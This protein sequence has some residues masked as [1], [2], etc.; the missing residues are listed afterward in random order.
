MKAQDKFERPGLTVDCVVFG[1]NSAA[2]TL[3][4]LLVERD[5]PPFQG[6]WALPGGFVRPGEQ[7]EDAAR[8]ELREETN[9]TNLFLEQLYTFGA[10][11]RDPRGWIV[12]VAYYALIAPAQYELRAATDARRAQ[13]FPVSQLPSLAFDHQLILDTALNRLKGKV[14]YAPVGFELLPKKFTLFQLQQLYETIL[15]RKLDNRNF[16]KKILGMAILR[17][18]DEWQKDVP[19]RAARLYRFDERRYRQLT[20]QGFNFE[21]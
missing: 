12:T 8:R 11:Q 10:P 9:V 7:L 21:L 13:W 2:G 19:H 1:L 3:E 15:E 17:E 6:E 4:A 5:V 16:R 20:K 14:R 18:L